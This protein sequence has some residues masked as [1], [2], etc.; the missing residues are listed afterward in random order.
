MVWAALPAAA[1]VSHFSLSELRELSNNDQAC[2]DVL[3]LDE[4]QSGRK[5]QYV[6][7]QLRAMNNVISIGTTRAMAFISRTFGM[8]RNSASLAHIQGLVA[9]LVD[10]FQLKQVSSDRSYTSRNIAKTFAV[11][12]RSRAHSVQDVEGA[13]QDGVQQGTATIAFFTRRR[14]TAPRRRTS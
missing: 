5:T 12:L 9:S 13:F 8:H 1:V 2:A 4:I 7:S 6:S 10:S 3:C 14:P 11:S